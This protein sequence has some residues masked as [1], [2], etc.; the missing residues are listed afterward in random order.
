MDTIGFC[1]VSAR[2]VQMH[3]TAWNILWEGNYLD[4][5]EIHP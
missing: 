2:C 5:F 4:E 3:S 1:P